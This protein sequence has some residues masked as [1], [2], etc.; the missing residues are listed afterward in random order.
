MNAVSLSVLQLPGGHILATAAHLALRETD[1]AVV[2][3]IHPDFR[4]LLLTLAP[5]S[6]SFSAPALAGPAAGPV[7]RVPA[8][9]TESA[10]SILAASLGSEVADRQRPLLEGLARFLVL[11]QQSGKQFSLANARATALLA[12]I[13]GLDPV[14]VIESCLLMRFLA[15]AARAEVSSLIQRAQ[16]PKANTFLAARSVSSAEDVESAHL[17]PSSLRFIDNSHSDQI[18]ATIECFLEANLPVLL[19]GVQG[20]GKNAVVDKALT[21]SRRPRQYCQLHLDRYTKA[22]CFPVFQNNIVF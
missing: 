20:V 3:P 21:R 13:G 17:I 6:S 22:T 12:D 7:H 9:S 5:L 4:V 19:C 8:L 2:T 1:S 16:L 14:Q 11:A 15:P 10:V 18:I